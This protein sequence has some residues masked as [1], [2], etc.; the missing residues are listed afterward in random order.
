MTALLT[1]VGLM[2]IWVIAVIHGSDAATEFLDREILQTINVTR[3]ESVES[4]AE[5]LCYIARERHRH[6]AD[7][8]PGGTCTFHYDMARQTVTRIMST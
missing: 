1:G 3:A 8:K 6:S 5:A 2:I 7:A 4:L